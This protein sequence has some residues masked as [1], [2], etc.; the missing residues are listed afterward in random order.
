[1]RQI[2]TVRFFAALG[3]I[4]LLA[5]LV[6]VVFGDD[7]PVTE[8]VE[9][10]P[11][12]RRIELV[13]PVFSVTGADVSI[14]DDGTTVAPI[15]VILDGERT[16]RIT[17]GTY[18]EIT[19]EELAAI[20]RCAV[21]ADLLGDAVVWFALV[22]LGPRSTVEMPAIVALEGELATLANGWQ[23]PFADILERQCEDREFASFRE[24][25]DEL[26][27]DFTSIYDLATDQL[28]DV[29]CTPPEAN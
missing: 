13:D 16:M 20:A 2:F 4:V 18:G 25:R 12:E 21:V 11:I 10:A 14:G 9:S 17:E 23:V 8:I 28:T 24:W 5:V 15:D 1:M 3:A 27:T 6:A 29:V 19:C 7:D 26:G 22:P